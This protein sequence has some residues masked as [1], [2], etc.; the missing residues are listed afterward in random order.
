VLHRARGDLHHR[1]AADDV[2]YPLL[3]INPEC[4]PVDDETGERKAP[5][6][7]F[8]T[9]WFCQS[10]V[11]R[12]AEQLQDIADAWD[13]AEAN[14]ATSIEV[15]AGEQGRKKHDMVSGD[16]GLNEHAVRARR[17]ATEIVW[18][19]ARV[20]MDAADE[21]GTR[22][23]LPTVQTVPTLATWLADWQMSRILGFVGELSATAMLR[24]LRE[25]RRLV[26]SAAYPSG[27]RK[28]QTGLPCEQYGTSDLGERVLCAGHMYAWVS[29]LMTRTP[30]LV[31]DVDNTHRL[32]PATW[33]RA[34]WKRAHARL[35]EVEV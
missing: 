15:G 31:C 30:D 32:D 10:C 25:A 3:C 14:L 8:G 29:P 12:M 4:R 23:Y 21:A 34:G 7:T 28:V 22:I 18:F 2:T 6:R 27:G 17:A 20:V 24:D 26:R 19:L 16:I 35:A 13:D 5:R 11:D 1:Q 9:G 33:E